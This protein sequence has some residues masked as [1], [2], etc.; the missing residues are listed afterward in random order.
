MAPWLILSWPLVLRGA[1][2]SEIPAY[3]Q[4]K[5]NWFPNERRV[6]EIRSLI[7]FPPPLLRTARFRNQQRQGT[8]RHASPVH[9]FTRFVCRL[10]VDGEAFQTFSL[11]QSPPVLMES[12]MM[13]RISA[14]EDAS[15]NE[16]ASSGRWWRKRQ[17]VTVP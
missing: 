9:M 7:E 4:A 12:I 13:H 11:S 17:N 1:E 14:E 10:V 16:R 15:P 8:G 6:P 3:Q 5:L 2:R